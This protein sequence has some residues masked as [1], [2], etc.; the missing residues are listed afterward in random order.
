MSFS[1]TTAAGTFTGVI[2]NRLGSGYS[3]VDGYGFINAQQAVLQ[4]AP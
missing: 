2:R 1:G 4:A 3:P